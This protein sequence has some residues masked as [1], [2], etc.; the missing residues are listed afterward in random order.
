MYYMVVSDQL[1]FLDRSPCLLF[2]KEPCVSGVVR[3][4]ALVVTCSLIGVSSG[5]LP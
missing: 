4:F 5:L 3:A 1:P 2:D